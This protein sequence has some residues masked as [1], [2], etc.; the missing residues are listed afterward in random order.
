[1]IGSD[2][3]FLD[4][5]TDLDAGSNPPHLFLAPGERADIIVDFSGQSGQNFILINGQGAL[6]PFPSGDP[7]DPDTSGQIMEFR[8]NQP[9]QGPDTSFNPAH[10]QRAL[11]ASPIVDIK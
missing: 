5:P 2:G 1:Q 6:V 11:R 3:G 7:P 4:A 9:L 10:P 8:V